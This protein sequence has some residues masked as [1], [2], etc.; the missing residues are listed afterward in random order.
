MKTAS[1][2]PAAFPPAAVGAPEVP[3]SAGRRPGGAILGT[4]A[5]L[6]GLTELTDVSVFAMN[7]TTA[8]GL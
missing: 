5:V 1:K 7:L 8:L 3:R 4:N 2:P 6:R